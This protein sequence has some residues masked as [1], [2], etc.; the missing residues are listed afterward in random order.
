MTGEIRT[1]RCGRDCPA[2]PALDP[3]GKSDRRGAH[4]VFNV[5]DP[6][7]ARFAQAQLDRALLKREPQRLAE[8]CEGHNDPSSHGLNLWSISNVHMLAGDIVDV[9]SHHVNMAQPLSHDWFLR[10]WFATAGLKQNDLVTKLDLPK[11]T[12]HRLWHGLQPYRRDHVEQIAALLNIHPYELLM[13]PEEA[14]GLRRLRSAIAEVA[15]PAADSAR[16]TADA[17]PRTGTNG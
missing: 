17:L 8:R 4:I 9:S 7:L 15:A 3:H 5:A 16:P 1:H 12:A 14:M 10:E 6:A 2:T 11:N 13:P